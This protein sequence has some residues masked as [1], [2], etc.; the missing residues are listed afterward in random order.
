MIFLSRLGEA[1]L[2]LGSPAVAATTLAIA[3]M[4]L[5]SCASSP[6]AAPPHPFTS[7]GCSSSP[8]GPPDDPEK[9]RDFCRVHDYRYWRGGKLSERL[10]AD[11]ELATSMEAAGNPF[12]GRVYFVGVR[13]GGSPWWPTPWRWGY[14]WNYPYGYR[15]LTD[16][17]KEALDELQAG[18]PVPASSD[19]SPS[20]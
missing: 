17:E 14:G 9:W 20:S 15:A 10:E 19:S 12:M 2:G 7:D 16:D 1:T 6:N 4:S 3:V 5:V 11:R 18:P 8:N 13:L